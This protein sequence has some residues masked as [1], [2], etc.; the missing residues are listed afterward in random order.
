MLGRR[1]LSVGT[2]QQVLLLC[3]TRS[4]GCL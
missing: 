2:E 3:L 4:W 1:L